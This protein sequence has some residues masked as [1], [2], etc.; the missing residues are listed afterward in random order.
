MKLWEK[1]KKLGRSAGPGIITGASDNDPSGILTYLQ[2]G[3]SFGFRTLWLTL[4]CLPLMYAVQEMSGRIG[5]VTDKGLIK[6]IKEH[7]AKWILYAVGFVSVVVITVNIGADLS[8]IGVIAEKLT[9]VSRFFWLPAVSVLILFF[10]I[11]LSY[12]KFAGVLKW[13][14]LSLLFYVATALY[15]HVDWL[16][17]LKSTIVPSISFTKDYILLFT[18]FLGTTISPYL[19]FWQ[20][21]EEVEERDEEKKEKHIR[22]FLVTKNELKHLRKDTFLGMFFSQFITWFVIAA[23]G[24]VAGIYGIAAAANFDEAS[25]VLKPLLGN[26]AFLIF[27]LGIIGTG[28]LAIPVL[29]G[30]VGYV[31]AE[32]FNWKEGISKTFREAKGFYLVI[33]FATL[34]GA[35]MNFLNIDPIQLLIYAAVLYTFITPP[36]VYL[37][38]HMANNK[39]IMRGRT[40]SVASNIFGWL[41]FV[42]TLAAATACLIFVL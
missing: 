15:L 28:L 33:I 36:L 5:Y 39:K 21:D 10:T 40:S 23:A 11:F 34:L 25:L 7:Y 3:F 26:F 17:A 31:L 8:A 37:I 32:I 2:S 18:A 42:F 20:A 16:G 4:F 30:S 29:A 14:T 6:V 12:P 13:L 1:I 24:Q 9:L 35:A 27:G 41:T 22:R 38:I 19:F